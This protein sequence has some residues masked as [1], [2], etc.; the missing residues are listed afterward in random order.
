MKLHRLS[1]LSPCLS[2]YA[3]R[4]QRRAQTRADEDPASAVRAQHPTLRYIALVALD[5][6]L[7][8]APQR[9]GVGWGRDASQSLS[10]VGGEDLGNNH[11]ESYSNG[12]TD[13]A[14]DGQR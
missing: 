4:L 1:R 8:P 3:R 6:E 14:A 5:V 2:L 13:C 11:G 7:T 10:L 12:E 9:R